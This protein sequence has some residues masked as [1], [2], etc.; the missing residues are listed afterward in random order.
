MSEQTYNRYLAVPQSGKGPGVIVLHAWWGLNGFFRELCDR[1]AQA[2]FVALAPDLYSGKVAHTVEEA[3]QL[4]RSSNEE[5]NFPP[6]ILSAIDELRNHPAVVGSGLG[7]IGFS[8]G[9]YWAFWLTVEKPEFFKAAVIFYA[10][11]GGTFD[12]ARS[13]AAY[14]GNFA[15]ND[16]YEDAEGVQDLEKRLREAG[17]PLQFYTYPGTSHWFFENDRPDA[18]NAEAAQLAWQ[19]TVAFL[20]EQLE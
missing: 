16:P 19:R 12:F 10:T 7:A 13:E 14:L 17:R 2:G 5:Q 9:G 6:I 18:Y 8:M 20:R 3:E 15:E 11:D 4:M 1:L